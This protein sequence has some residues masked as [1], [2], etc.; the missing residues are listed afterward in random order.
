[1]RKVLVIAL[2]LLV[3]I[4]IGAH[5][6]ASAAKVTVRNHTDRCAWLTYYKSV[7]AMPWIAAA[8]N[9]VRPNGE[10]VKRF[11][12]IAPGSS[13]VP[14]PIPGQVRVRVEFMSNAQCD[15]PVIKDTSAEKGLLLSGKEEFDF[16][17]SQR[18]NG[19]FI[20]AR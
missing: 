2:I 20:G 1:M 11:T 6:G 13:P 16:D 5:A 14:A 4:A 9:W 3:G 15:H 12:W 18:K 7:P 10:D 17:L 19:Y 8:A